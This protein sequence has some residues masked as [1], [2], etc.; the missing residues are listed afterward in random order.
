M[1]VLPQLRGGAPCL[2]AGR[3][4]ATGP[5]PAAAR[6]QQVLQ[7][8]RSL[9]LARALPAQELADAAAATAAH[10][11]VLADLAAAAAAVAPDA[12]AAAVLPGQDSSWFGPLTNSLEAV[13]KQ[14][15]GVLVKLGVPY[16]YG[17]SIILLTVFVKALTYPLTKKQVESAMAVQSLKPRIDMIKARYGDDDKRVQEETKTLYAKAEVNPYAGCLPTI[18]TIPVF[19]GLYRSLSQ[20]AEEGL[21]ESEGFYWIPNLA[22]PTSIAARGTEWLL[23]FVDGAPPIGWAGAAPY[24]VLP[25]LLVVAQAI[26][27]KIISPPIDPE[28]DSATTQR[29]LAVA[30]PLMVGWFALCVPSGLSLYYFANTV[31]TGLMQVYLR[32]LGGAVVKVK[33]LGPVTKVG[34][35]RRLGPAASD[36]EIWEYEAPAAAA[37]AA[38]EGGAGAGAEGGEAAERGA[39]FYARRRRMAVAAAA[40]KAAGGSSAG[41][42]G[43]SGAAGGSGGG[44][45]AA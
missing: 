44:A 37:A 13:L 18:A 17:Y 36:S 42:G 21:L 28:S 31:F 14:I 30:L 25:V 33:D 40:A 9:H 39:V 1:S 24:L 8:K 41:S 35:A 38:A 16:S 32:K 12:A 4:P 27:S 2:R 34:S 23:P 10:A 19:I 7:H 45:V 20:V 6:P 29:V 43:G 22:G 26:S 11:H 5:S 15:Q 3:G